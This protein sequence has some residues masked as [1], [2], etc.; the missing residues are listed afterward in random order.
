MPILNTTIIT[1][2]NNK[3]SKRVSQIAIHEVTGLTACGVTWGSLIAQYLILDDL[4]C[5]GGA[6]LNQAEADCLLGKL[7]KTLTINCP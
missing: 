1:G 6:Y 7:S 4:E 3:L 2:A 5:T